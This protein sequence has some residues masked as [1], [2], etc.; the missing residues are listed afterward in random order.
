MGAQHVDLGVEFNQTPLEHLRRVTAAVETHLEERTDVIESEACIAVGAN[1]AEPLGIQLGITSI[2]A[3]AAPRR[4]HQTDRFVV[5]QGGTADAAAPG[6]FAYGQ[7]RP[8]P[9]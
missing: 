8:S 4:G 7:H 3:T 2:V 9:L 5:Q 6:E 1:G